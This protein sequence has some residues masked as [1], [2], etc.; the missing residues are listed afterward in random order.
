M[1]QYRV[2]AQL[3]R[4]VRNQYPAIQHDAIVGH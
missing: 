3:I 1:P 2:L 4:A